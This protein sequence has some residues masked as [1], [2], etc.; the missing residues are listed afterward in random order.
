[1]RV[2][3]TTPKART[4]SIET[5]HDEIDELIGALT[6][7]KRT[8][9]DYELYIRLALALRAAADQIGLSYETNAYEVIAGDRSGEEVALPSDPGPERAP[10][11]GPGAREE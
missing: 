1:M 7:R 8:S 11:N 2:T 4:I 5:T 3:V 9:A 6:R 10:E